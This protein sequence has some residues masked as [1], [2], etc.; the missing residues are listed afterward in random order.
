MLAGLL[1]SYENYVA[2]PIHQNQQIA[3]DST[4]KDAKMQKFF[5]SPLK[6]RTKKVNLANIITKTSANY[7]IFPQKQFLCNFGLINRDEVGGSCHPEIQDEE[8]E[9]IK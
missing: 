1:F 8:I 5:M 3:G 6:V 2:D 9:K 4:P 7:S